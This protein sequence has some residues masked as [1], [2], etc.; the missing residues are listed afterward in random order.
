MTTR[1]GK[2]CSFGL[3]RVP[4]VNCCVFRYFPFGFEGRMWDLIVSVPDHCLSFYFI[5]HKSQLQTKKYPLNLGNFLRYCVNIP[6]FVL[7]VFV[8]LASPENSEHLVALH[9][10]SS[11]ISEQ[12]TPK[13]KECSRIGSHYHTV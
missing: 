6:L 13:I 8:F 11:I 12:K 2:S 10:V 5:Y 7:D 9:I 3:P 1:L 4:F